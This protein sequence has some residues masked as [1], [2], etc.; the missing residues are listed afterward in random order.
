MNPFP[1]MAG[2]SNEKKVRPGKGGVAE[3]AMMPF[4]VAKLLPLE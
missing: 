1:R 4:S 3:I 2:R